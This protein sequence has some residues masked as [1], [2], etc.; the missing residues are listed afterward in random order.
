M[1]QYC[2]NGFLGGSYLD[3]RQLFIMYIIVM[4]NDNKKIES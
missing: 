3:I 2:D 1:K 4:F